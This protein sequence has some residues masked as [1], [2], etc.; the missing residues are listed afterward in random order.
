MPEIK[1]S[2]QQ[3]LQM[4]QGEQTKLEIIQRNRI[5]LQN[6]I[7]EQLLAIDSLNAVQNTKE[8][9]QIIVPLG[10]GVFLD[11]SLKNNKE[12]Q[13]SITG[14]VIVKESIPKV[15][16]KIEA[17]KK[18]TIEKDMELAREQERIIQNL[19]NMERI[20]QQASRKRE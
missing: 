1:L 19:K 17:R 12:V 13:A 3:V 6:L 18:E 16:N 10:A 4:F 20:L 5:T 11:A 9:E 15:I 8:N 2:T 7:R 14:D